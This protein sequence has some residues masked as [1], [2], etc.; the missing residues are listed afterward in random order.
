LIRP[1]ADPYEFTKD[2]GLIDSVEFKKDKM[3]VLS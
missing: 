3:I 2:I 1:P